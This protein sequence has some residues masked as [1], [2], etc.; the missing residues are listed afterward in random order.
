MLIQHGTEML[1]DGVGPLKTLRGQ[2]VA[3]LLPNLL[4]L[5]DGSKT[6]EEL[7]RSIPGFSTQAVRKALG[8]LFEAGLIEDGANNPSFSSVTVETLQFL[9]RFVG[10]TRQNANGAEA[11]RKL[12]EAEVFIVTSRKGTD[13]GEGLSSLLTRTGVGRVNTVDL[14]GLRGLTG[15]PHSTVIVSSAS[16]GEEYEWN[17]AL[18]EW[19]SQHGLS[20]I[21]GAF[22]DPA[23]YADIGPVFTFGEAACY[24]CFYQLHSRGPISSS[25]SRHNS[26]TE[27]VWVGLLALEIIY[28]LTQIAPALSTDGFR[29]Y[30]LRTSE[31]QDFGVSRIPGCPRCRPDSCSFV[32]EHNQAFSD[33]Y[34][35][36]S[37]AV[38]F[39]DYL[40]LL[41]RPVDDQRVENRRSELSRILSRQTKHLSVPPQYPL[42]RKT[43]MS[44]HKLGSVMGRAGSCDGR[45]VSI[46]QLAAVLALTAGIRD[47]T[48]PN[49]GVRR[50]APTGGNLGSVELYIAVHNVEGI[51][52]GFYFYQPA[53]HSLAALRWRSGGLAVDEFIRRAIRWRLPDLP[54]VLIMFTG[55]FH[56][57]A[58][59]YGA[60]GYNL[61][62]LDAGVAISQ[63]EVVATA[64]SLSWWLCHRWAY[65]LIEEQL[66]LQL[67]GEQ[68]TGCIAL[69]GTISRVL[70]PSPISDGIHNTGPQLVE[71]RDVS[72]KTPTS[73][74][75]WLLR[76][77]RITESMLGDNRLT[78]VPHLK[79]QEHEQRGPLLP[80]PAPVDNEA[81]LV[82]ILLS[83]RSIRIFGPGSAQLDALGTMLLAARDGDD[84][85]W[86]R[87]QT[88]NSLRFVVVGLNVKGLAPGVYEYD[89]SRHSLFLTNS[90]PSGEEIRE[91]MIQEEFSTAALQIWVVGDLGSAV[92]LHGAWG[93]KQLLLRG[94]TA[95]HRLFI[96]GLGLGLCGTIVAGV[97]AS[98]ARK[99]LLL[100]GYRGMPLCALAMGMPSETEGLRSCPT[101]CT[102]V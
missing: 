88:R 64:L 50:W 65:D 63:L 24:R 94:G 39:T 60:F 61:V 90:L 97:V 27:E 56:R 87:E 68:T 66:H 43:I 31:S 84:R 73:I 89:G 47:K 100:D 15:Y 2:S 69:S 44:D 77:S 19:C 62:H 21:R 40:G 79:A 18:D 9:R 17:V 67:P 80:L 11:Y 78:I 76:D 49:G 74:L 1:V 7:E 46:D 51:A 91:L 23:G 14:D 41:S 102:S 33:G 12:V 71:A 58:K 96:A 83:R 3:Q 52:P 81:P 29:R 20:W 5:M 25:N 55:A 22:D 72:D 57:V 59:K 26:L 8:L 28:S 95:V 48:E 86:P 92:A 75:T 30:N 93:H 36:T 4:P 70:Q 99:H 101:N 16:S 82:S 6:Q 13:V 98:K 53:E 32:S 54:E 38:V 37:P 85:D 45:A 35:L 42:P 10:H 34:A